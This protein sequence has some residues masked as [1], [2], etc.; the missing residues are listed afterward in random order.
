MISTKARIAALFLMAFA[1]TA[2]A[3][4]AGTSEFGRAG[5]DEVEMRV[6]QPGTFSGSFGFTTS[7]ASKGMTGVLGGALIADRLWLFTAAQR[8]DMR[9]ATAAPAQL[10][11]RTLIA[12]PASAKPPAE[13]R[14][15]VFFTHW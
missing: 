8:D 6:K 12:P 5:G 7:N 2:F 14:A 9:Q 15:F 13:K 4:N 3:Q 11:N 10:G 1:G